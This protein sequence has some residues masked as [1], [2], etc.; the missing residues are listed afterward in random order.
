MTP[1]NADPMQ[2]A[3]FQDELAELA[4]GILSGRDRSE[5]LGHVGSCSRCAAELERLSIVADTLLQLAPEIEPPLG[6]ELRLAERLG[7]PATAHRPRRS[8]GV[9]V[10]LAAAVVTIVAGFGLG[11]LVQRSGNT[12]GQSATA[13]LTSA[14]LTSHGQVLGEVMI[15]SGSPAWMFMT[16]DAGAWSG[17][18]TCEVTMVGGKVERIGVFKLAAGYGAWAAPMTS[19]AGK[20]RSAQL[21]ASNGTVLAS[22]QLTV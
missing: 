3:L 4:L 19:S 17:K 18:V 14:N 16:I 1:D 9:V 13:N 2:C 5:L 11:E 7:G 20:V 21:I 10:L 8:R 6:F 22:A 12:Q 15:S